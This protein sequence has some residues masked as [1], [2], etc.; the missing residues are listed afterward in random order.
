MRE[1]KE[2]K[3]EEKKRGRRNSVSAERTFAGFL[4]VGRGAKKEGEKRGREKKGKGKGPRF[5]SEARK[6]RI[7]GEKQK[8]KRGEKRKRQTGPSFLFVGRFI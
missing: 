7:A 8:K 6:A 4:G 3:K 2:K 1:G 5:F